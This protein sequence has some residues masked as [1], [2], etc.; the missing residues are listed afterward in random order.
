MYKLLQA[1]STIAHPDSDADAYGTLAFLFFLF[2]F[3]LFSFFPP[4]SSAPD[5]ETDGAYGTLCSHGGPKRRRPPF[6]FPRYTAAAELTHVVALTKRCTA[7][8]ELVRSL[9]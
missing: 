7:A 2:P 1:L 8:E 3:F 9:S 5:S 4:L 6:L